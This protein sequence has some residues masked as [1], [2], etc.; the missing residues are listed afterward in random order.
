MIRWGTAKDIG[1]RRVMRR[2]VLSGLCPL[3]VAL[4]L[5]T[6]A[7]AQPV[8]PPAPTLPFLVLGAAGLIVAVLL[9]LEAAAVRRLALGGAVAERISYVLLAV[10]CLTSAVLL[11][12][13]RNFV[14]AMSRDQ[15]L[16]GSQALVIISMV[17]LAFYFHRVRSALQGYADALHS[18]ELG[19]ATN[20]DTG[21]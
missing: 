10:L 17:L 20:T 15:V 4:A 21:E 18:S 1:E 12:W 6:V 16:L 3:A 13:V 8:D 9:L 7:L 5:P 11:G 19:Q 2:A 14:P